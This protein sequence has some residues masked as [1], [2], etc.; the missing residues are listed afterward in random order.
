MTDLRTIAPHATAAA[1]G[2]GGAAI[3]ALLGIPAA[4]LIGATLGVALAGALGAR[5]KVATRLRDLAFATIGV[6]LGAGIDPEIVAQLPDWTLSLAMLVLSLAATLA[7]GHL[8]LT[9][10]F[11]LDGETA[12]LSSSPGTMSNALAIA[13]EGRGDTTAV[14]VLQVL[15]L[16]VLVVA[17]PPIAVAIGAPDLS[18]VTLHPPMAHL[19]LVVLLAISLAL[20]IAGSRMGIPAASLIAGMVMSGLAHVFALAEGPAPPWAVFTGFAV[21]GGVLGT[22][23]AGI[24]AAEFI[25]F[26]GAGLIVVLAT[27]AVAI[28][29]SLVTWSLT[30]LPIG[31]IVIAYAPGGVEAM[32]AIGLL[33]G[34]DPAYIAAHHFARILILLILVPIALKRFGRA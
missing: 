22:R 18:A 2:L 15:R 5:V 30:G 10:L 27:L 8:L 21:T 33:L 16:L 4:P 23:V 9:R 31:Q 32:A 11:G 17:V 1:A 20:G 26:V 19:P 6:S 25:R 34:F 13:A 28:A 12:I 24:K 14:M 29:F 7:V 3:A